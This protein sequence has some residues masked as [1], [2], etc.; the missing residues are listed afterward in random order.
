MKKYISVLLCLILLLTAIP[1]TVS[2]GAFSGEDKINIVL[3]PGHGGSNVGAAA[4]GVGEKTYTYQLATLIKEKLEANGSF[5]VYFTRTGDYDL[6][7]YER[8]VVANRYNAD[9]L[10]SLH[11]DGNADPGVRGVTTYTSVIDSYAATTLSSSIAQS[12]SSATGFVNNGVRRRTDTAGY[13]WSFEK[14]W[15]CQDPSLGTLSD[16]YGIPTWC[17]K[18]GIP[19]I[20]VEH[21]YLSNSG[22]VAIIC[23]EGGI[24]KIAEAEAQA[25]IGYYTDHTHTYSAARRDFPSNCVFTGKQ[26]E[27]C[28]VCGHR[29]NVTLLAE[30]L[31]NHY[32]ITKESTPASCGVDGKVYSECRISANLRA[33]GWEGDL[34]TSTVIIPAPTD[35]SYELIENVP[36]GHAVDGYQKFKC[37]TCS[38]SFTETV[39]GEDHSYEFTGRK[40][41]T[42]TEDG[43]DSYACT[44]C[45]NS[46]TNVEPAFGHSFVDVL[47]TEPT[48]TSKGQ[49]ITKCTVCE[50]EVTE[51]YGA[52]GHDL[53]G[54]ERVE[55]TCTED[56]FQ[57]GFC[58]RCELEALEVLPKKGHSMT[59]TENVLPTC[60]ED[61]RIV[62][63]CSSCDFSEEEKVPATGHELV[64]K[65]VLEAACE[66]EGKESTYCTACN[67]TKKT[68]IPAVEHTKSKNGTC[69]KEATLFEAGAMSYPCEKG[70]GKV[71]FEDIPPAFS[72]T[73]KVVVFSVFGV[74]AAAL[75]AVIVILILKKNKAAAPVPAS[76]VS[77]AEEACEDTALEKASEKKEPETSPPSDKQ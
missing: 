19:S 20:I 59:V 53:Q 40:E 6:E 15:D 61:G 17:A 26:S 8:A 5:N 24:E 60:T 73:V 74:I 34:H 44:V 2:A 23:A 56:G 58:Q 37:S 69:T 46:F 57:K 14:Q 39:K 13:Y 10:I 35:H 68:V 49:H 31:S 16:Y 27:H 29:R 62:S 11:F 64:H 30:D 45:G 66:R 50:T 65:I 41:P 72:G 36:A 1:V 76:D 71:F 18:F 70:C 54:S 12:I 42:C 33:K 22:D 51:E 63:A 28:S 67:Y 9:I 32:W 55:P 3:D 47:H 21:G 43:G 4:R 48:C 7:L 75:V 52:L 38:A 25:I 77:A